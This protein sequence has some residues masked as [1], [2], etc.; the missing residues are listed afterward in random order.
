MTKHKIIVFKFS[1]PEHGHFLWS[2]PDKY[3]YVQ[4]MC[5][6]FKTDGKV[7]CSAYQDSLSPWLRPVLGPLLLSAQDDSAGREHGNV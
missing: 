6:L 3:D 4:Y 5:V 2:F 7:I 1:C